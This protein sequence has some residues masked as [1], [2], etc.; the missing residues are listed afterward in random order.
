MSTDFRMEDAMIGALN[1][2][3]SRPHTAKQNQ[4]KDT[5]TA[6][7]VNIV[8]QV[9]PLKTLPPPPAKVGETSGA[10]T[11]P[12]SSSPLV[13]PRSH[14]FDNRAKHLVP[15][16]N[17]FSKLVSK[18]DLEDFN[19]GTLGELV[20]V[21]QYSAFHLDCM[22]IYSKAKVGRYNRK[23]KEDIQSVMTKVNAT[24]KRVGDLN[25]ENLK[26]IK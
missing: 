15:Y 4:N 10:A 16:I 20:G 2:K 14:L 8:Q 24:E 17:E 7:R 13:G 26:L 11:D 9:P 6:K 3:C 25:L 18:R 12:A 22:T 5:P 19:G 23:M 21:M 1:Q